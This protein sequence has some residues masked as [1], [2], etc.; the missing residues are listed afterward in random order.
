MI[1]YNVI[2]QTNNKFKSQFKPFVICK[3]LLAKMFKITSNHLN[4]SFYFNDKCNNL[5]KYFENN[6]EL[7]GQKLQVI[8][9]L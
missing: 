8:N 5:V 4:I 9:S 6:F 7:S 3:Y 2:I 1:L